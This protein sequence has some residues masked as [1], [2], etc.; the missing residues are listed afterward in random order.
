MARKELIKELELRKEE[1][2]SEIKTQLPELVEELNAID[3][4]IGSNIVNLYANNSGKSNVTATLT[5]KKTVG[6]PKGDMTWIEYVLFMLK[7]IGGKGKSS[8]VARA[9][10]N[11]NSSI[12][13]DRAIDAC[14]DKLSKLLKEGKINADTSVNK[15]EGYLYEIV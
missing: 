12:S 7:E 15:K 2:Y 1:I 9:I 14:R 8:D 13:F 3:K 11:A 10:V 5:T 6:T 4:I